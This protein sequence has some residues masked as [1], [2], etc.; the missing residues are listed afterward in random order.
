MKLSIAIVN[1]NTIKLLDQCLES[2]F[3]TLDNIESE[4]IVVDNDS[5]DGSPEMVEEKY[6]QVTLV[7]MHENVGFAA[8]NNK[9]FGVSAGEYFLLLNS[10]TIAKQGAFKSMCDF[11]DSQPDAGA[12]GCRLLNGDGTLQRSCS[13]FPTPLSETFDALYL[14]K[15]FPNSKLFG[16]YAMSYCS[17]NEPMEVDFAGGSSLLLRR[18]ALQ[19][20]G[21]LDENYFMYSEEADLCYRLKSGGWKV[22]FTPDG[23]VTH[24]GG[25][26]AKLD[27]KRN[28]V[29][30]YKSKHRFM[31]KHYG[32]RS[33]FIYKAV[34]AV[35]A[36]VRAIAWSAKGF[37]GKHSDIWRGKADVQ[38]Q[39]LLWALKRG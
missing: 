20:V 38:R 8:A 36:G 18:K 39:I 13:P 17:F 5:S 19:H 15:L 4:V 10:D 3:K 29:E 27:V 23:E 7:R 32:N 11:M 26:S 9:A 34:V 6:P 28:L 30:L 1:W 33:A 2:V 25:Q 24:F 37:K 14:S 31:L 21:L 35:S 16:S 22:Y 12:V